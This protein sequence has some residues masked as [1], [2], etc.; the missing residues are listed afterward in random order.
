MNN[1]KEEYIKALHELQKNPKDRL[2]IF[3]EILI[4]SNGAIVSSSGATAVAISTGTA[5]S[6]LF[7]SAGLASV[8]G[9]ATAVTT[10][11]GWTIGL[12]VLGA[13]ATHGLLKLYKSGVDSERLIQET[14]SELRKKIDQLQN[15][16]SRK[17]NYNEKL[18][19]VAKLYKILF[20]MDIIKEKVMK[21]ILEG[22]K[23]GDIDIDEYF[24][25]A[26]A[27]L[28][29]ATKQLEYKQQL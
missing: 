29:E 21:N 3:T 14:I 26:K 9:V 13:F 23:N 19:E 22:M 20:R 1:T 16:A 8:F 11:I 24:N 2:K 25:Y 5:T 10:P 4:M 15:E 12:G 6:T 27:L 18:A 7:G 28:D 17:N